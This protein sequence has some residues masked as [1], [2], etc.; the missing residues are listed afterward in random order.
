MISPNPQ[1]SA[2]LSAQLSYAVR[3]SPRRVLVVKALPDEQFVGVLSAV[4]QAFP[5]AA[6]TTLVSDPSASLGASAAAGPQEEVGEVLH[7]S[8]GWRRLWRELSKGFEV[9][10][11]AIEPA[12]VGGW[13]GFAGDLA[14]VVSRSRSRLACS[15][16]NIFA[17]GGGILT[18]L[19]SGARLAASLGLAVAWAVVGTLLLAKTAIIGELLYR[20][21]HRKWP[22]ARPSQLAED[23]L[24]VKACTGHGLE[25]ATRFL[26]ARYPGAEIQTVSPDGLPAVRTRGRIVAVAVDGTSGDFAAA[27]LA[28]LR[29]RARRKA[30]CLAD[31]GARL[32]P[33]GWRYLVG[34]A[35]QRG[36][37]SLAGILRRA[38]KTLRKAGPQQAEGRLLR[39]PAFRFQRPVGALPRTLLITD[40]S[41]SLTIKGEGGSQRYRVLHK[42]EQL[43]LLGWPGRVRLVSQY[44]SNLTALLMDAGWADLVIFHRIFPDD[45]A[46]NLLLEQ[47]AS[48]R[49]PVIFDID[50]WLFDPQAQGFITWPGPKPLSE[51]VAAYASLLER[52]DYAIGST[53]PLVGKLQARGK[54][55]FLLRNCLSREWL[56]LAEKARR[57]RLPLV[58]SG[59]EGHEGVLLG[60]FSGTPTH[61]R[62]FAEIVPALLQVMKRNAALRLRLVGPCPIPAELVDFQPRIE[63]IP[64]V[65][66]RKLPFLLADVD[67]NLAPLETGN[68]FASC[69]SE[70]KYLEA[71]SVGAPTIASAIPAYR[72]AIMPGETG[73][74]AKTR[75]EWAEAIAELAGN[76]SLRREMGEKAHLHVLENYHPLAGGR[77]LQSILQEILSVSS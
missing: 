8:L 45:R 34:V 32:L 4:Q 13:R 54:T 10:I 47:F 75:D 55:T 18:P 77:R 39:R 14:A 74:L 27:A 29:S 63:R 60:Y 61:D 36:F 46:I 9:C 33:L 56:D 72:E 21:F 57:F 40:G 23:L 41:A 58:L 62:D 11:I 25:R 53:P 31:E 69:K 2:S 22:A 52:C 30:I 66:W 20:A 12:Q 24:L 50:D 68:P 44:R 48:S 73:L 17:R 76:H 5:E 59:A 3:L 67:I 6:I 51:V 42:D 1:A 64:F 71:A 7:A 43:R 70:I 28:V 16:D 15:S 35:L 49:R 65:P 37:D 19:V 26:A 38:M